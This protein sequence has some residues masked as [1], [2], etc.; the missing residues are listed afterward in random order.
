[1]FYIDQR[2]NKR[3]NCDMCVNVYI[4]IYRKFRYITAK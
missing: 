4:N 1:M 2:N 3:Q